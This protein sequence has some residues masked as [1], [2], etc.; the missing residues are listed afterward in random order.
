M[1]L[2]FCNCISIGTGLHFSNT[3]TSPKRSSKKNKIF[4]NSFPQNLQL[5]ANHFILHYQTKNSRANLIIVILSLSK[6]ATKRTKV[7]PALH[8]R[9]PRLPQCLQLIATI[10]SP[11]G[12]RPNE[13]HSQLKKTKIRKVVRS[14][15]PIQIKYGSFL[16]KRFQK[17]LNVS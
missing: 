9:Y 7:N 10:S 1:S 5:I 12:S 8:V 6:N 13:H 4:P 16:M 3:T 14:L 15:I 11:N 17:K 2:Y